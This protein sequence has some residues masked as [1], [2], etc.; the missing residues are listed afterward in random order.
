M[1][2]TSRLIGGLI[3]RAKN[4]P[5][6]ALWSTT[7]HDIAIRCPDVHGK[8]FE[9]DLGFDGRRY[10]VT[11]SRDEIYLLSQDIK[12]ALQAT[13][14]QAHGIKASMLDYCPGGPL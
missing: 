4:H 8:E 5:V 9:L 3:P 14:G 1:R 7:T 10:T 6:N 12:N 11:L 13:I 2:V